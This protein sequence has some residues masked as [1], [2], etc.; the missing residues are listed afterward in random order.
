MQ[1]ALALA[2]AIRSLSSLE[3]VVEQALQLAAPIAQAQGEAKSTATQPFIE[4]VRNLPPQRADEL[5]AIMYLGRGDCATFA[6]MLRIVAGSAFDPTALAQQMAGK[7][8]LTRYLQDGLARWR[9][10]QRG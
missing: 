7:V 8:P 3:Q 6:E 1:R 9:S 5:L 4:F 10:E 2:S